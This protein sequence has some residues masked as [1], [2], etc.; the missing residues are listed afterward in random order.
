MRK[1]V[2]CKDG[3]L[4]ILATYGL[5]PA[6]CPHNAHRATCSD[7]CVH[8]GEVHRNYHGIVLNV[9]NGTKIQILKDE[10]EN[11]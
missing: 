10:R 3:V 7:R 11:T 4:H 6:Q 9:C 1:G 8:F 2:I 5:E